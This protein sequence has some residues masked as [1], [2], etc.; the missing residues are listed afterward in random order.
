MESWLFKKIEVWVL[1]LL[2]F[3]TGLGA[4][5][6]GVIVRQTLEGSDRYGIVG[7]A[8]VLLTRIPELSM[9][10]LESP[11]ADLETKEQRFEGKS[12]FSGRAENYAELAGDNLLLLSRYDGNRERSVVELVRIAD[13]QVL[14][15]WLPDTDA[16]ID[17]VPGDGEFKWLKR[18]HHSQRFRMLSPVLEADGGLTFHST[19]PLIRVDACGDLQWLN[20]ENIFHH[21][22]EVDHSGNYWVAS[23]SQPQLYDK[24][25]PGYYDDTI[26]Q[27]SSDGEL[28]FERSVTGI[29]IDNDLRHEMYNYDKFID[30][31]IHLNDIQPVDEDGSVWKRGDIFLS[32]GHLN[33]VM[34]YRPSTDELIWWTQQGLNHQHDVDIIGD[35]KISVF[36]NNSIMSAAG[37]QVDGFNEVLLFDLQSGAVTSYLKDALRRHEVR[38][39]SQGASRVLPNGNLYVEETNY[40]RLLEFSESGDLLWEYI[41]RADNGKV[42]IMNWSRIISEQEAQSLTTFLGQSSCE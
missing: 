12:G 18:D 9:R 35:G 2:L 38:T 31:P 3:V 21:M 14:H 23:H 42:Y 32:L 6:F 41:N 7:K 17:K 37:D 22:V 27:V 15:T 29:L 5:T 19:T 20:T 34:L 40:G 4:L 11:S 30:D 25:G 36:D 8:S 33:M 39:I 26:S 28:L 13:G 10:M 16:I 24:F 1:L